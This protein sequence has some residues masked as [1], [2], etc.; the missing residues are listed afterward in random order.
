MGMHEIP[1]TPFVL[2][3]EDY[4]VK[5]TEG[6]IAQGSSIFGRMSCLEQAT[7]RNWKPLVFVYLQH[8]D[9]GVQHTLIATTSNPLI[10]P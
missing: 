10:I 6:T 4:D 3:I 2:F 5:R 8:G 9:F 1:V 7:S